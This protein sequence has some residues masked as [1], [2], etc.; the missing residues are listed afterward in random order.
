M[1][2]REV[3]KKSAVPVYGFAAAWLLYCLFL[4]LYRFWH[5]VFL[6][7]ASAAV[8]AVLSLVF[9]GKTEYIEEPEEPER[10][11]DEKIDALLTEGERAIAEMGRLRDTIRDPRIREKTADIMEITD[12]I[13][14]N[15]LQDPGDYRQIKRF[16]DY[17]LPSTIKLLHAY[18]RFSAADVSG[19]NITGTL[20]RIEDIL[21][22]IVESYHKQYDALFA[23][24]ALDIETDITVL[25]SML[26]KEGLTGKDFR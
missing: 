11:G 26:K 14:K 16:A 1:K 19:E 2:I 12:K 22:T 5:F 4:P 9:P 17:Y 13:F 24:Q 15:V 25:E 8:Y 18:D 20:A 23:N 3:R 7:C 6:I 10:T 21:D